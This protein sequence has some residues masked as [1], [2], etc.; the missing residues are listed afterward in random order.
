M[1]GQPRPWWKKWPAGSDRNERVKEVIVFSKTLRLLQKYS[2]R[3]WYFPSISW[4]I[5]TE[6]RFSFEVFVY[7]TSGKFATGFVD[8]GGVPWLANISANFQEN[9]LEITLILLSGAWG[10]WFMKKNRSKKSCGIV[11]LTSVCTAGK[12]NTDG[13]TYVPDLF[14]NFE[15][16]VMHDLCYISPGATKVG[17]CVFFSFF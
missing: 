6:K 3:K 10:R 2:H 12:W 5:L 9:N 14:L 8:S 1:Q 11:P 16:C 4:I 13:C 15:A 17:I 7:N